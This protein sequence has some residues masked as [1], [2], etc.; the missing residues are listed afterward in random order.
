MNLTHQSAFGLGAVKGS[1][2]G[3]EPAEAADAVTCVLTPEQT[4][5]PYYIAGEKVRQEYAESVPG[6][7]PFR[8]IRELRLVPL[9][10]LVRMELTSFRA[11]DAAHIIDLDDAGLITPEV[12]AALPPLLLDRLAEA[13]ARE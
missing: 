8:K 2:P 12:E 9:V 10:D 6:L 7:G 13:R 11:K 5:G 3:G 1:W 4:E